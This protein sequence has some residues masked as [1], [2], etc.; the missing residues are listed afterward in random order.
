MEPG[1]GRVAGRSGGRFRI[2]FI[3]LGEHTRAVTEIG[4]AL[5]S[6]VLSSTDVLRLAAE[7]HDIYKPARAKVDA[8]SGTLGFPGHPYLLGFSD[9]EELGNPLD[10]A[11]A[12]TAARLHHFFN[13]RDVDSWA[14]YTFSAL[15]YL[16]EQREEVE[17]SWLQRRV[18]EVL[19]V[20][21]LADMLAA[22]IESRLLSI[23]FTDTSVEE[24]VGEVAPHIPAFALWEGEDRVMFVL[25]GLKKLV[26]TQPMTLSLDYTIHSGYAVTVN[27]RIKKLEDTMEERRYHVTVKIVHKSYIIGKGGPP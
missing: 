18:L 21:H 5:Y 11:V 23:P 13:V 15:H 26:T 8:E 4:L 3:P 25:H 24:T 6:P 1:R 19:L 9:F 2:L 22:T 27:N 20:L 16:R 7:K 14:R 10:V 17:F 12:T